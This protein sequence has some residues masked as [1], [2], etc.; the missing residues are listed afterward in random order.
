[1]STLVKTYLVLVPL[2]VA[3]DLLWL[4]LVMKDFYQTKLAHL[5]GPGVVWAPAIIFYLVFTAAV[6]FFA[7]VPGAQSGSLARTVLLGTLFA[8]VAY[9]TYDLTN[10]ATLRDW[11]LVV[12]LVDMAWGAF[13]GGVLAYVGFFV[14]RFFS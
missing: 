9:A 12:T 7:V 8:F 5:M 4:G 14:Y 13:V 10:H 6:M 3:L 1:M 2:M 11:P